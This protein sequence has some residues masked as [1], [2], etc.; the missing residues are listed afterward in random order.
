MSGMPFSEQNSIWAAYCA[1][2]YVAVGLPRMELEQAAEQRAMVAMQRFLA[3]AP[4]VAAFYAR[5]CLL[6]RRDQLLHEALVLDLAPDRI[7]AILDSMV[8]VGLDQL[9][10]LPPGQGRVLVSLHYSLY[11]SLLIWWLAQAT[12]RG[13]FK[14]LTVLFRSNDVG[15][16]MLSEQRIAEFERAGVWSCSRVR[17]LDRTAL[18]SAAAARAL[19][20]D[21]RIGGAVLVLSDAWLLPA[22]DKTLKVRIGHESLGFPRGVVWLAQMSRCPLVPVY[23]QPR[24]EMTHGVIFGCP[25][26]INSTTDPEA[27][28]T[29]QHLVDQTIMHDPSPWEGWLRQGLLSLADGGHSTPL[30]T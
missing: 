3:L 8:A 2:R 26:Y 10:L 4:E 5:R 13:L 9:Q 12:A 29:M 16:Y 15:Q 18:G 24:A 21:L 20:R 11:S 6:F 23:L 30:A 1:A 17:L 7:P 28:S 25:T 22:D 19:L 27:E 14:S